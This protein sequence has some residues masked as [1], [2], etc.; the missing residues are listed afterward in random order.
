MTSVCTGVNEP[1]YTYLVNTSTTLSAFSQ[2]EMS[3]RR[4]F[5]DFVDLAKLLKLNFR[6]YFI[7]QRPHRNVYQG[8]IRMSPSFIEER[9]SNLEKYLR[10]LAVHPIIS[11]SEVGTLSNVPAISLIRSCDLDKCFLHS[12]VAWAAVR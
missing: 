5:R 4:R 8:K 7:P 12:N 9:R 10:Q 2:P 11:R 3:V 1:Y 6:G